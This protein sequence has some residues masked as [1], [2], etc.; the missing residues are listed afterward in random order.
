MEQ[1]NLNTTKGL[2]FGELRSRFYAKPLT[3]GKHTFIAQELNLSAPIFKEG[4]SQERVK[5]VAVV[6]NETHVRQEELTAIDVDYLI[7][8]AIAKYPELGGTAPDAV[9]EKILGDKL[10]L[11]MWYVQN[12]KQPTYYNWNFREPIKVEEASNIQTV[13]D[14]T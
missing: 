5:L 2:T 7:K 8:G 4:S 6:D 13:S 1:L 3:V 11:D 14:L 12:V 10:V 9:I